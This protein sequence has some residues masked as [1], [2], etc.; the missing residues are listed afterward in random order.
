MKRTDFYYDLPPELIAQD[1]L[2]DRQSS[3]LMCLDKKTGETAHKHF[4]DI[5]DMLNE[6]DCLILNDTKVIPARLYGIKEGTGAHI[7]ILLLN[8]KEN[9]VWEV[10]LK[11]GRRAKK[12]TRVIFGDGELTMEILE[13][14]NDGN[15]LVKF[16]Y[17]GIF[18]EVLDRLGEMPLPHYITKKLEDKERYQTVYAKC[19][20]SA[21]APAAGLHFTR[22]L[23]EKIEKKNTMNLC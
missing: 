1:P 16:Y 9:D 15:R 23:M 18:E 19:A 8:R 17:E 2:A 10:I 7:E 5:V 13:V 6:G 14:V 12:G 21:A 22:E 3:R 20:G 11:P 4:Y